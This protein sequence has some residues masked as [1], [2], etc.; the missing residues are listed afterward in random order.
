MSGKMH[1]VGLKHDASRAIQLAIKYA[2]EDQKHIIVKEL[3]GHFKQLSEEHY[4]H[5][6][7]I[8]LLS[9]DTKR[10]DAKALCLKEF[11]TH[12]SK[13]R[14]TNERRTQARESQ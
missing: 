8:K 6:I 7:V 4:G 12:I 5:Y 9:N 13:V 10:G 14:R 11:R 2:N 3:T 1:E